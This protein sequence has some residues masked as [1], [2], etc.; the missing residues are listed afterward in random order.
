MS[1]M[2]TRRKGAT[3]K[4]LARHLGVSQSLVSRVLSGKTD[5]LGISPATARRI[6]QAARTA[7]YRPSPLATALRSGSTRMIGV[8]VKDFDDPFFGHMIGELQ[9]LARRHR[10]TLLLTGHEPEDIGGMNDYAPSGL[11]ILGSDYEVDNLEP[12]LARGSRVLRIG[13]APPRKGVVRVMLD[14]T[15]G[16]RL[17]LDHL[18]ELGHR[19]FGFVGAS[20]PTHRRRGDLLRGLLDERGWGAG[21]ALYFFDKP[22]PEAG[23][24]GLTRIWN[25]PPEERPTALLASDD[26]AAHGALRQATLL[27]VAVPGQLSLSGIDDLPSSALRV[28]ALT[29][30]RQPIRRMARSALAYLLRGSE[31][32]SKDIWVQPELVIRESTGPAIKSLPLQGETP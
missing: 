30:L 9:E 20:L 31:I 11:L 2:F 18:A 10:Y 25:L 32:V 7:G 1:G 4:D 26:L 23:Q 21:A 22:T 8:I 29:T 27:G 17:L 5:P 6:R 28:P 16:L 12:C 19:R 13:C 14:E 24:A 3:Q 15:A